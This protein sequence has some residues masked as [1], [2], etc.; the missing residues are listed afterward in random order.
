M[1][2]TWASVTRRGASNYRWARGSPLLIKMRL[3]Q[4]KS[5]DDDVMN[6]K[7]VNKAF[8]VSLG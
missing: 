5:E 2:M 8:R 4:K 1:S 6:H 3:I 7:H